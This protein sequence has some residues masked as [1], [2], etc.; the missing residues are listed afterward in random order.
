MTLD[1]GPTEERN[2][3]P[4]DSG[5]K[6]SATAR[7][8]PKFLNASDKRRI[9]FNS[10]LR[11]LRPLARILLRNGA[12]YGEF[13]DLAK[14]V[15][16]DVARKDFKIPGRKQS[17]SRISVI[18]GLTRKEVA[19]Q[20]EVASPDD[21][22]LQRQYH[23]AAKVISGWRRDPRFQGIDGQPAAL[24]FDADD[25]P[26]FNE[27]V[28][29][30]SGDMP[31]RAVLDELDRVGAIAKLSDGR[32]QLV[33]SAYVPAGDEAQKLLI[34]GKDTSLLLDTLDHNLQPNQGSPF[35]QRKVA[36]DNLP[37]EALPAFRQL[38]AAKAQA[39]LE[40]L[41]RYLS[42]RDRDENPEVKGTGRTE[43][44]IGIYYFEKT[45]S[46]ED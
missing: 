12:T 20:L 10:V 27:L 7:R 26:S 22:T 32:I 41:D 28:R 16:T 31:S 36:Y 37:T 33:T 18:T 24:P 5:Y 39:L 45:R 4:V 21:T 9:L 25:K 46:E 30:F 15:F 3:G 17:T 13:A 19:K 38:S 44:G 35:F 1:R 8:A 14:W 40:E 6:Y 34:M 23:R 29:R 43:A 2:R 11:V 42:A